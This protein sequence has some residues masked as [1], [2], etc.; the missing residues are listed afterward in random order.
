M[1]RTYLDE[2][3]GHN[4]SVLLVCRQ[5]WIRLVPIVFTHVGI[6]VILA[7][8]FIV[9]RTSVMRTSAAHVYLA[10][11]LSA[12]M[13][14][15]LLVL[16]GQIIIWGYRQFVITNTRVIRISGVFNKSVLD[17]ALEKINDLKLKQSLLAR[18]LNYGDIEIMTASEKGVDALTSIAN[19]VLFK[20]TMLNA[21]ENLEHQGGRENHNV[22]PANTIPDLIEQLGVLRARGLLTEAEFQIKKSELLAKL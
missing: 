6:I 5:H 9:E 19:A 15:V 4:E 2:L 1:A 22:P 14:L 7:G 11:G 12:G 20:T 16:L 13:F 8:L 3:L 21:K 17:S 18:L 10:G